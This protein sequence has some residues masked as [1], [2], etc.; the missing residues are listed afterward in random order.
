LI[1]FTSDLHLN[2]AAAIGLCERPFLSI[3]EMNRTL[4]SNINSK[5]KMTDIVYM[6]G[7]LAHTGSVIHANEL[8]A[9][10]HGMKILIAGNHDK[11]YDPGLFEEIC[12]FK[13]IDIYHKG[14]R[15]NVSLMHY[16]MVSWPNKNRYGIHLHGCSHNKM[17]YNQRMRRAGILR[18]DV[19]VDAN[20][21]YPVSFPE[22]LEYM[23]L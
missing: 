6:L 22:I 21:Y 20:D 15:Y 17:W 14:E 3:E 12:Y 7:D 2:H 5:V 9:Q 13:E 18:Y 1:W 11:N 23:Q 8:I 19:G 10:I 16:P 4:I